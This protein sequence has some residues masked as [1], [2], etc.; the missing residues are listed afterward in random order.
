MLT[1]QIE[2]FYISPF[3]FQ[4]EEPSKRSFNFNTVISNIQT[5]EY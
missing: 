5:H 2:P 4:I 3:I 1:M